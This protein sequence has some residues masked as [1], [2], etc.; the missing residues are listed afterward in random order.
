MLSSIANII[1]GR[2]FLGIVKLRGNPD[3][4]LDIELPEPLLPTEIVDACDG[5]GLGADEN[6]EG[7]CTGDLARVLATVTST[8][9]ARLVGGVVFACRNYY[10][11][12]ALAHKFF[13]QPAI[14]PEIW[15]NL[16][17]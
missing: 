2:H 3:E 6:K 14:W 15:Q 5:L 8:E 13:R 17:A 12:S 11:T 16:V 9:G 10:N 4:V 7:D 1:D